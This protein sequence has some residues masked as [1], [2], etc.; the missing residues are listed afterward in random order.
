MT[1]G[2]YLLKV[3][4]DHKARSAFSGDDD[5]VFPTSAGWHQNPA[6][7]RTRV[8]TPAIERA[9]E[10]LA[11]ADR[12]TIPALTPHALRHTY[13]SLLIAQGED[14]STVAAQM[15]H[16]DLSTTLRAYTHVM[17]HR[18]QGVAERLDDTLRGA[19]SEWE[20]SEKNGRKTSKRSAQKQA[21]ALASGNE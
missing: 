14:L 12:P 11:A 6:N 4:L 19:G 2:Q 16:A 9:N 5:L 3:L 18:R 7:F 13:C 20:T 10:R 1:I 21:P 15:R 8:L 17:K